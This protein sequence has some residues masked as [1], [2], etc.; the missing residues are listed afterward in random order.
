MH[1]EEEKSAQFAALVETVRKL[2]SPEGCPWD[3]EQTHDSLKTYVLEETYEVLEA[4]DSGV[5]HKLAD[6]LG[7]LLLQI[8][9]HA[10]IAEENQQFDIADVCRLI[11]E[12]LR[13]RHP[14]VFSDTQVSGIDEIWAN[15]E[16]IKSEEPANEGRESALDGVPSNLP[17]L[18]RA[19]KLTKK[20]AR[21][22]FDWPHIHGIMEKLREETLELEEAIEHGDQAAVKEE[23]GDLIF[24]AVNIA[25]F[26][27]IDPEEAL[28]ETSAKFTARFGAIERYA[29]E[30][31]KKL[32][33]MTLEEMD[34]AWNAAKAGE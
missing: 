22:G 1:S 15:W 9:L 29:E 23:L 26:Q 12:K 4:I 6:E 8:L 24:T 2:R 18:M 33:D 19:A 20:A 21:V 31:G 7:D 3:R 5:P 17:A 10:Q 30:S 25:R 11:T 34:A 14:H 27:G 16:R 28:R 32:Q 13:R